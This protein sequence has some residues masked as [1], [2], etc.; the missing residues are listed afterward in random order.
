V[1]YA[2]QSGCDLLTVNEALDHY[3]SAEAA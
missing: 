1:Q 3:M 2:V